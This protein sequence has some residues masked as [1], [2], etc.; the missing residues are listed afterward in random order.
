MGA[1]GLASGSNRLLQH[2]E[3]FAPHV[4]TQALTIGGAC[5]LTSSEASKYSSIWTGTKV[6]GLT[7]RSNRNM[8]CLMEKK[9]MTAQVWLDRLAVRFVLVFGLAFLA[10]LNFS[11]HSSSPVNQMRVSRA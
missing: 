11:M 3:P 6:L 2:P 7:F 1:A 4:S 8:N 10:A 9:K 5:Q